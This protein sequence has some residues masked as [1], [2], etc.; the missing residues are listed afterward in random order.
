MLFRLT[1]IFFTLLLILS[2]NEEQIS[3]SNDI[4]PIL[5]SR[6][7]ACHGGV[8]KHGGLSL[9]TKEETLSRSSKTG[10]PALIPGNASKSEIYK[11]ILSNDPDYAMP[12]DHDPI[13]HGEREKIKKWIDQ[14]AKWDT[15]WSYLPVE[16]PTIPDVKDQ[17]AATNIDKYIFQ[18]LD[19]LGLSP[20]REIEKNKLV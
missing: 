4:K 18:K 15:H 14:G 16:N 5:N 3:Y 2:C 8:K 13:P 17:W 9:L 6:C 19:L 7:I 10:I 11:R 12:R 20:N 1:T